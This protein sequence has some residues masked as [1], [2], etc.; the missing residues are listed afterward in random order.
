MLTFSMQVSVNTL[1]LSVNTSL[2]SVNT[3]LLSVN[4]LLF[5]KHIAKV[6]R[7]FS[8]EECNIVVYTFVTSRLDY[9]NTLLNGLRYMSCREFKTIELA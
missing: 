5:E 1:L 3:L 7:I 4:I 9:C 8:V 2:L 6:R